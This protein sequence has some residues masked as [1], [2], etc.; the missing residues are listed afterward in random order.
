MR[1]RSKRIHRVGPKWMRER[2]AALECQQARETEFHS[3]SLNIPS[4]T[5]SDWRESRTRGVFCF[6]MRAA[7]VAAAYATKRS[8]PPAITFED[9]PP[10]S[11]HHKGSIVYRIVRS[12]NHPATKSRFSSGPPLH[13]LLSSRFSLANGVYRDLVRHR[14]S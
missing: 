14:A 7:Q 3:A 11:P 9:G 13:T 1:P 5:K 6:T 12:I 10:Q 4:K 8:T 2:E